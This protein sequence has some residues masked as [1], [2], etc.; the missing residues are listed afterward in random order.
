MMSAPATVSFG[1]EAVD[2]RWLIQ[3][4]RYNEPPG[5]PKELVKVC[6]DCSGAIP[7][8]ANFCPSCGAKVTP[9][10][11]APD[12]SPPATRS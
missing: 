3:D 9:V 11:K 7:P 4:V 12:E 10:E 5:E 6:P 8:G 1:L 2:G